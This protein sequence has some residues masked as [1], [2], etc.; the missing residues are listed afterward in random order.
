MTTTI[1]IWLHIRA[2]V[3]FEIINN[4]GLRLGLNHFIGFLLNWVDGI[5]S[6]SVIYWSYLLLKTFMTMH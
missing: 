1:L 2:D 4:S 3:R 6:A 5:Q